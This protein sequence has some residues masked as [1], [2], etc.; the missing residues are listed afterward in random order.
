M[1]ELKEVFEMA[2]KQMGEPDQ[3]SWREQEK[4]QRIASRNKKLGAFAV[5]AGLVVAGVVVG[6][7]TLVSDDV[8][9]G[10]SVSNPTP[11]PQPDEAGQTLSIIDVGSGTE[12]AFTAPPGASDF[13]FTLDGSMVTYSDLDENGDAQVF[14]MD[15]DGS[16]VRQLTSGEG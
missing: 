12:T 2:T 15:A 16:N 5:V 8:R 13:D 7:S 11:A 10:V 3:D 1:T 6:I 14:V 4:R 9:P